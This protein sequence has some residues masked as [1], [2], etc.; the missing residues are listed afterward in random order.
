MCMCSLCT[1]VCLPYPEVTNFV[2]IIF[3]KNKTSFALELIPSVDL[4]N[5]HRQKY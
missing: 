1:N 5:N 2:K 3:V 4:N